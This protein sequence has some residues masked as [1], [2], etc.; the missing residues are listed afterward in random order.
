M[1]GPADVRR[2]AVAGFA[3]WLLGAAP[4][5]GDPVQPHSSGPEEADPAAGVLDGLRCLLEPSLTLDLASQEPGIVERV[6]V[7]RG[8]HVAAGQAVILLKSDVERAAVDLARAKLDFGR[9]K[10]QRNVELYRDRLIS[11]HERDE[12]E[13]EVDIA[14]MELRAAEER[15][16]LRTILSPIDG[17][18][19]E[20]T[21]DPGEYVNDEPVMTI[22]AVDPLHVEVVAPAM[23]L[24]AIQLGMQARV[25]PDVVG[26]VFDARVIAIDPVIDATSNTFGVRLRLANPD[27][28]IRAGLNCSVT[29]IVGPD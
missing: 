15:L 5:S 12:M 23:A 29:F 6:L 14:A 9:R 4:A 7:D 17:I 27:N 21:G 11:I 22:V 26:G 13:T 24:G 18:V 8:D 3:A 1:I 25:S 10:V 20:R 28:A 16:K 19:A 2:L